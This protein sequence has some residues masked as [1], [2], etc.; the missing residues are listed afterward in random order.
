MKPFSMPRASCRTF[1]SGARQLVVQLALEI[2]TS[3]ALSVSWL[4]P[5][6]TVLSTQVAGAEMMKRLAPAVRCALAFALSAKMQVH[7][8]A[9]S[10][11]C[12]E[13][14]SLEGSGSAVTET[15]WPLGRQSVVWGE[16]W[17]DREG[18]GGGGLRQ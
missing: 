6:T 8:S 2:T 3:S 12:A 15:R 11:P 9:I 1:A 7:S 4:T 13:C 10:T 14:G 16:R 18:S 17:Q 5:N